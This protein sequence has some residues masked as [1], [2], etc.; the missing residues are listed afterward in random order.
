M[1]ITEKQR[2]MG[3]GIMAMAEKHYQKFRE[4]EK[5]LVEWFGEDNEDFLSDQMYGYETFDF[6]EFLVRANINV[7]D[8]D[9]E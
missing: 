1:E 5:I 9:T 3:I 6:E 4:Y 2:L 7:E 8:D